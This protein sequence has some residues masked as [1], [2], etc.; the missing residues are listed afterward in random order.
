MSRPKKG[1]KPSREEKVAR[2]LKQAQK[3]AEE[4]MA[5]LRDPTTPVERLGEMLVTQYGDSLLPDSL[6]EFLESVDPA[7]TDALIDHL[8]E[9]DQDPARATSAK[10]VLAAIRGD[11]AEVVRL[12]TP[13]YEEEPEEA[14]GIHLMGA[15]HRQGRVADAIDLI[16]AA[17]TK[18][19]HLVS[20]LDMLDFLA[21]ASYQVDDPP[22]RCTCPSG[23]PWSVCC[24]PRLGAHLA[25]LG[26]RRRL[27]EMIERMRRYWDGYHLT[28]WRQEQATQWD[29]PQWPTRR[30]AGGRFGFELA[31]LRA[32][33]MGGDNGDEADDTD[34]PLG[35][36]SELD[37]TSPHDAR[38]AKDW[39]LYGR[40]GLWLYAFAG[41]EPGPPPELLYDL[42][43]GEPVTVDID[44]AIVE[45]LAPWSV[46]LGTIVPDRGLWRLVPIFLV[47]DPEEGDLLA[48]EIEAMTL[49]V[50]DD[51]AGKRGRPRRPRHRPMGVEASYDDMFDSDF[52]DLASKV[53]IAALPGLC[54]TV[55]DMRQG[56][57]P[58]SNTDGER[59]V[60]LKSRFP[61]IDR[62]AMERLVDAHPDLEVVDDEYVW[63]GKH[64]SR[65]QIEQQRTILAAK[66]GTEGWSLQDLEPPDEQRWVRGHLGWEGDELIVEVNSTERLD[67]FIEL[68]AP[69]SGGP[70]TIE[71]T[72]APPG[73]PRPRIMTFGSQAEAD[74]WAETFPDDPNPRFGD[75]SARQAWADPETYPKVETMLRRFEWETWHLRRQGLPAPDIEAM[76]SRIRPVQ[77]GG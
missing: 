47:L 19:G 60:F 21:A 64:L 31:E 77:T 51:L 73:P 7:R 13:L 2:L 1:R 20:Q 32:W 48:A 23:G 42:V 9:I 67:T 59:L 5:A 46:I 52:A 30:H 66:A 40:T 72:P 55:E 68:I 24:G 36:F 70:P 37:S 38:L 3:R 15:L 14:Y 16:R 74:L 41:D 11:L 76:R 49:T 26:D 50:V 17:V 29:L 44:P 12:L 39:A 22:V 28:P 33:A 69:I 4:L 18:T 71:E 43:G 58:L 63:W 56:P 34:C 53:C 6:I 65:S 75:L 8:A 45:Q 10:A 35:W 54:A 27:P 57:T 25:D 62:A 61:G